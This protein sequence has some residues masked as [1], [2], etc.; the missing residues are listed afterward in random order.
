M[1]FRIVADSSVDVIEITSSVPFVTVPLKI[2]TAEREYIDNKEL[3]A[4]KMA[5]ELRRYKGK[6]RS[7][8]PNPD[9]YVAAFGDAERVFCVTIT[10]GLSGSCNAARAAAKEYEAAYPDRRVEVVDSLSTGPECALIVEK[11]AEL[12]ES[13]CDFDGICRRVA[14]YR[15][16]TG[17]VF[18]LESL[19]NLAANGRVN[20]IVA[21]LSGLLG[22]RVVGK[23]SDKGTLEVVEKSRGRA[24]ALSAALGLM[25]REGYLGGKVRIHHS[26][27][28]EAAE[29]LRTLILGKFPDA[30]ITVSTT[31]GLCSFYAELGGVLIGFE[32][33]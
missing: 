27:N 7:S 21:K 3:D 24:A 16:G 9:E 8:C 1:N 32:K 31:G 26:S 22:I 10:S 15:E 17:L 6:S 5:E 20:P 11:I 12:I 2:I 33:G 18:A 13:G 14:E 28:P 30:K 23:A 4:G 29:A 19:H 25:E